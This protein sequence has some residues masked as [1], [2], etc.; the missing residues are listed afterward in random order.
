MPDD[1]DGRFAH[2]LMKKK[3]PRVLVV[4]TGEMQLIGSRYSLSCPGY[5]LFLGGKPRCHQA[6]EIPFFRSALLSNDGAN[7]GC[8]PLTNSLS[9]KHDFGLG[10]ALNFPMS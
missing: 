3:K 9:F 4:Q 2:P 10:S 8:F 1:R 7:N 6:W 5:D